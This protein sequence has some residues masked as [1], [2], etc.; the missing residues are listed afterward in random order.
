MLLFKQMY[1][2]S[3]KAETCIYSVLFILVYFFFKVCMNFYLGK[4][5][6]FLVGERSGTTQLCNFNQ[7]IFVHQFCSSYYLLL[8]YVSGGK[9]LFTYMKTRATVKKFFLC[10]FNQ[11]LKI[12]CKIMY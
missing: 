4:G 1:C 9:G 2:C 11:V 12:V 3:K 6:C 8:Y 5:H 7:T 10:T